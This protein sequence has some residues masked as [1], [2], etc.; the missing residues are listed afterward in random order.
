MINSGDFPKNLTASSK[1]MLGIKIDTKLNKNVRGLLVSL[2]KSGSRPPIA[3]TIK[4]ATA[5]VIFRSSAEKHTNDTEPP[6]IIPP[7]R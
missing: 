5:C 2:S 4:T 6:V 1:S 3:P 7:V